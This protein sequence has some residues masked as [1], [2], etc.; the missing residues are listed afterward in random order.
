L[1]AAI[2]P[3]ASRDGETHPLGSMVALR[4]VRGGDTLEGTATTTI[5]T[6]DFGITPP[7]VGP[8]LSLGEQ[9]RLEPAITATRSAM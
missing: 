6:P 2:G 5:A 8:V 1:P 3:R 7:T 9:V 4:H